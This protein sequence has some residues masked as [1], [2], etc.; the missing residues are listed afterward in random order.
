MYVE[1]KKHNKLVTITKK[2]QI[3]RYREQTSDYQWEKE[4]QYRGEE[5]GRYKLLGVR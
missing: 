5:N 3:D 2:K 1:Y 4:G